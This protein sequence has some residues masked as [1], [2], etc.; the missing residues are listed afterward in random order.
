MV[1]P[2]KKMEGYINICGSPWFEGLKKMDWTLYQKKPYIINQEEEEKL[3]IQEE[4]W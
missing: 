3:V 2:E 4:I 1:E